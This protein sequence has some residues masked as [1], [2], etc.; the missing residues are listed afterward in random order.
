MDIK[1]GVTKLTFHYE[2]SDVTAENY[3]I[4]GVMIH[5]EEAEIEKKGGKLLL[6]G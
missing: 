2:L 3:I 6:R 4:Y 5:E 1:D